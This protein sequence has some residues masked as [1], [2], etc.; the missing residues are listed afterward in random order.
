MKERMEIGVNAR[1]KA[2]KANIGQDRYDY[3]RISEDIHIVEEEVKSVRNIFEWYIQEIPLRKIR[4][5]L[6]AASAPQNGAAFPDAP[7]GPGPVVRLFSSLPEGM[8]MVSKHIPG[9]G[10]LFK[11]LLHPSSIFPPMN[12]L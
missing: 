8:L 4:E 1:L 12:C 3:H 9:Q 5:R 7:N 6:I 10:R 2:G 11:S